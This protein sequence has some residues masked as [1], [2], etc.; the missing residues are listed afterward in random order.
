MLHGFEEDNIA[1][2]MHGFECIRRGVSHHIALAH[3]FC[4]VLSTRSHLP[5]HTIHTINAAQNRPRLE[6]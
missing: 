1:K 5:I 4:K 2:Y 6:D 3:L